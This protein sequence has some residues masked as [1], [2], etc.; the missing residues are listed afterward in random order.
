MRKLFEPGMV[1]AT[2]G[3]AE[4]L[5]SEEI[6]SLL[7]RHLTGDWGNLCEEDKEQ[8]N[9]AVKHSHRIM[10]AYKVRGE[11][12]W[13]VTEADRSATTFLLPSEY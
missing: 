12:I 13:V 3:A 11:E 10:S 2:K 5:H 6:T 8:N 1:V 7:I 9:Q 4:F